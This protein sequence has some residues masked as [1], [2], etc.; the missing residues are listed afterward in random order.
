MSIEIIRAE[1]LNGY[2]IKLRFS[3]N[4]IEIVDFKTFLENSKNPTTRKYLAIKL[5]KEFKIE[6]G[7][8]VWHDYELCFPIIDLYENVVLREMHS[9]A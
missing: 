6:F 8:L 4:K 7:D 9:L 3:D 5:F 2:R 1:Y